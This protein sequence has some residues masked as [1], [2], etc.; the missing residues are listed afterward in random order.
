[1]KSNN[2]QETQENQ[3][4]LVC[5]HCKSKLLRMALPP[6]TGY[7]SGFFLVC[8]N[9]NC[10]HFVNGWNWMWE[11]YQVTTSYRHHINPDTGKPGSLPVWSKEA[12]KDRIF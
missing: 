1:V 9:D 2:V 12:M 5:P 4:D 10:S 6:E 11:K 7:D 8:F 3:L